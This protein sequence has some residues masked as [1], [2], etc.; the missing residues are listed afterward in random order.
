MYSST[1]SEEFFQHGLQTT[2]MFLGD[3]FDDEI[4]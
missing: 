2:A 4:M 1:V 3:V